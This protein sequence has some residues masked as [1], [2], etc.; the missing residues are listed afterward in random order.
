[1]EEE[2][3]RAHKKANFEESVLLLLEH[4]HRT[5]PCPEVFFLLLKSLLRNGNYEAIKWLQGKKKEQFEY[6]PTKKIYIEAMKRLGLLSEIEPGFLVAGKE[7]PPPKAAQEKDVPLHPESVNRYYQA[8]VQK[9]K[10]KKKRQCI[11]DALEYDQRNLEALIYLG[12]NHPLSEL[13]EALGRVKRPELRTLF[14][15][16]L[17][18]DVPSFSIFSKEFL[19]PFSCCR[20]SKELFNSKRTSEMFQLAQYMT[21]VYPKHYFTYLA[22]GMYYMLIGK[23]SDAKRALYSSIQINN[24]FGIAWLLLGQCQSVLC[25]CINAINCYEKAEQLMEDHYAA[26]LG[27]ALEYHKMRNYRKAEEKYMEIQRRYTLRACFNPYVSLLL[28]LGRYEQ[29]LRILRGR[30]CDETTL[31]LKSFAHLFASEYSLAEEALD[32]EE[33]A[34][35]PEIGKKYYLLKGYIFHLQQQYCKAIEAYQKAILDPANS[36]GS[37]INDLL[38]LAIKNS[39]EEETKRIVC[40]YGDDVFE[41]LDLK[42]NTPGFLL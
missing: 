15:D 18:R 35:N 30:P 11:E 10:E 4:V 12:M 33:F 31:L 9:G 25:E 28:T 38:E 32:G 34:S 8:L 14:S 21:M 16:M 36:S 23:H 17:F 40:M 26:S 29:A 2:L 27:I 24:T 20:L 1:M 5:S 13:R 19:S 3:Y 42:S 6:E 7:I 39:L 22:A 37:L 41:L